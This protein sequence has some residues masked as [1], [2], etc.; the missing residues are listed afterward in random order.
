MSQRR[1]EVRLRLRC[2]SEVRGRALQARF[3]TRMCLPAW[4][5]PPAL[6]N[7][8]AGD[9][10]IQ[11]RGGGQRP[12]IVNFPSSVCPS[13]ELPCPGESKPRAFGG[14]AAEI[15]GAPVAGSIA[16]ERE[17]DVAAEFRWNRNAFRRDE[18]LD[19]AFCGKFDPCSRV[20]EGSVGE[21]D[22]L[23]ST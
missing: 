7:R 15:D 4:H 11:R 12:I 14:K 20:V 8:R 18:P 17:I 1:R 5:R 21:A 16:G 3:G 22:M 10:Q 19:P 9:R 2:R 13:C 6:S 23:A